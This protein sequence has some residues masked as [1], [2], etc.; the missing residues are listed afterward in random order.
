M[1][2]SHTQTFVPTEAEDR[3]K[4]NYMIISHLF[5]KIKSFFYLNNIFV[6]FFIKCTKTKRRVMKMRRRKHAFRAFV[7]TGGTA[8]FILNLL[9]AAAAVLLF[10]AVSA[11][12]A[13]GGGFASKIIDS[14]FGSKRAYAEFA[15]LFFDPEGRVS[16]IIGGYTML[17]PELNPPQEAAEETPTPLPTEE[18][19]T[20]EVYEQTARTV[21]EIKNQSGKEADADRLV[22][23]P[24]CYTVEKAPA[25]VLIVHTH[26][27]ES[28]FEQDRSVD[29]NKNMTAVGEVIAKRLEE[30][31]IGVIHDT[32]VHDY[33][34]Y[35]GAYTRSC[36]TVKKQ[37]EAHPE[38]KIVLDVH[39]DAVAASDGRKLK[40]CT[41]INGEKTA[42]IMFVVGTDAQLEHAFWQENLKLALKIQQKANELYPTLM[43][44]INLRAQRF[45]QQLSKGAVIIEVG[46][47]GNT[48][49]EAKRG[50]LL[51]A[52]A[53][54]KV[55][56]GE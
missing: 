13:R 9:F 24:L 11:F 28:Y 26:T 31:G 53:A 35:S 17:V 34:S 56:C 29:E 2:S 55:L 30:S 36:A 42:Q 7:M 20:P 39:R 43:R 1:P 41:D 12:F 4:I 54:V 44:P 48:L 14:Y 27:T 37:L 49:D 38:I 19:S 25:Q 5:I 32:T 33:P 40:L 16:A 51:I 22:S 52:D 46:T 8:G 10:A 15:E 18:P 3:P 45:N 50:A 6:N 23:E 21:L 47:N